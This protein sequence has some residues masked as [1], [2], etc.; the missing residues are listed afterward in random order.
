MRMKLERCVVDV[1]V[2][3]ERC[4]GAV[5][6]GWQREERRA[7]HREDPQKHCFG[8][9]TSSAAPVALALWL[10]LRVARASGPP[11]EALTP[12]LGDTGLT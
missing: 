11:L 3:V 1:A 10:R 9:P 8:L 6:G 7:G 4:V 12:R 2:D 5:G